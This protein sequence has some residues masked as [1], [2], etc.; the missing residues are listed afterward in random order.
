MK[1]IIVAGLLAL[2]TLI[3]SPAQAQDTEG[4]SY[5][6]VRVRY[7]DSLTAAEQK[8][9][10][11][12]RQTLYASD[13]Y[14][15]SLECTTC[16]VLYV[17]VLDVKNLDGDSLGHAVGYTVTFISPSIHELYLVSGVMTGSAT[18]QSEANTA[19]LLMQALDGGLAQLSKIANSGDDDAEAAVPP[20]R[21][22]V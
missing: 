5:Y 6:N 2:A 4:K 19:T 15:E 10:L 18:P 12:V 1:Q 9:I 8:I 13:T 17:S 16:M 11:T 21:K 7:A 22:K 3:S 14:A 20:S